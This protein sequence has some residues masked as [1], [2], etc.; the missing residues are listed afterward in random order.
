MSQWLKAT[1]TVKKSQMKS[2][3]SGMGNN[4]SI[5]YSPEITYSYKFDNKSFEKTNSEFGSSNH[6]EVEN[7]L[8]KYTKGNRIEILVNPKSPE[9]SAIFELSTQPNFIIYFMIAFGIV[10]AAM[11]CLVYF[12]FGSNDISN[13]N[14]SSADSFDTIL[15]LLGPLF[16]FCVGAIFA[17][18]GYYLYKKEDAIIKTWKMIEAEVTSSSITTKTESNRSRGNFYEQT[19]FAPLIAYTYSCEG[20]KYSGEESSN[21]SNLESEARKIML[22]N[23]EGSKIPIYVNPKNPSESSLKNAGVSKT[24]F[25][26][27]FMVI[28]ALAILMAI[29]ILVFSFF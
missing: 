11:G 25:P 16:V 22:Q 21:Y 7:I 8:N 4:K 15:N 23:P 18:I 5:M 28:G 3:T 29:L 24:L 26:Y 1:A 12:I 20:K 27:I 2:S 14:S 13:P 6:S 10:F 17:Y 19:M 9:Q